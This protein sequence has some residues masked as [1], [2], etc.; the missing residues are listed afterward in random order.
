MTEVQE[1]NS[2]IDHKEESLKIDKEVALIVE[3]KDT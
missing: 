2:E 1:K 3:K